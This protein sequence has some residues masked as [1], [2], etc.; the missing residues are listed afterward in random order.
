MSK[1]KKAVRVKLIVNP[2]A[3]NSAE[4]TDKLGLVTGYLEKNGLKVDVSLARPKEKATT[5]AKRAVKDGY[6]IVIAM[7]GDGTVEAVMRGILGSP[8]RLGIV[9]SGT[10][11]NIATSLGIPKD[12]EAACALIASD[13]TLEL[14]LGQ[15]TTGKGRKFLFFEKTTIGLLATVS[16]AIKKVDGGKSAGLQ[17]AALTFIRQDFRP[18]V[19]LTLDQER[20]IEVDTM[21]VMVSIAPSIEP[22]VTADSYGLLNISVYPGAG[23]AE[24]LRYYATMLDGDYSDDGKV[25]HY[26]ARKL[27]VK[28]SPKLDVLVDGVAL[29]KGT[30]TIKV[31]KAVLRIITARQNL[32]LK[33]TIAAGAPQL[34]LKKQGKNHREKSV[35][36]PE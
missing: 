10:E 21:L 17:V 23:K 26:R 6:E 30:V 19:F 34:V 35:I 2:G 8:G 32:G 22:N 33:E 29:D 36:V 4:A 12:L 28:T 15:V 18:K 9:P 24:L 11:N 1:K 3:G 14:D 13:N 25:Q 20:K 7:G 16:P 31:R 27:K 5:L